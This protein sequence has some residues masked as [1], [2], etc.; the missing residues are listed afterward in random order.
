MTMGI[1]S[2]VLGGIFGVIF[3]LIA[4]SKA[5]QYLIITGA[6]DGKAK[7]GM[8]MGTI[9]LILGILSCVFFALVAFLSILIIL[10]ETVF[11]Y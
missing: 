2:I 9:G 4:K 10:S 7:A 11:Y 6:L 8:I 3:G 1:L 5:K